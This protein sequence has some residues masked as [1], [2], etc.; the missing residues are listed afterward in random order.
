ME[1]DNTKKCDILIKAGKLLTKS[2][3]VIGPQE[4]AIT[5]NRIIAVGNDLPFKAD[6]SLSFPDDLLIPGL[7]DLHFHPGPSSWKY[8]V[9]P[10]VWTL[11]AGTTTV[12][13]QGDA[14]INN[15]DL[16]K[17]TIV[18]KSKTRVL[19]A[20]SISNYGDE[21]ETINYTN[22]DEIDVNRSIEIINK[23]SDLIWGVS[24]NAALGSCN[25]NNPEIIMDKV[26]QVAKET[27]K[28]ILYGIRREPFDWPIKNQLELLRPGD[29]VT[30][31]FYP[32]KGGVLNQNQIEPSVLDAREKGILFDVG[33]GMS[34]FDFRVAETCIKEGFHPDT[35][36]TDFYKRHVSNNL[37][38]SMPTLISKLIAVGM[39]HNE[40]LYKSTVVPAQ[41]LNQNIEYGTIESGKLAD[42]TIIKWNT[43]Q[44][45]LIDVSGNI[46]HS[47]Y[48]ESIFTIKEGVII[49][50][51]L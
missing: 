35:I 31:C 9:E 47:E 22:S 10:D 30:Y 18:A 51:D 17:K 8:A 29:V 5:G 38:H 43:D 48:Y 24:F 26:L 28:P 32:G 11:T 23:D 1:T 33:H 6:K 3:N 41:I 15:W 40:A 39:P 49:N 25:A 21:F 19:M 45:P 42:L 36:S 34:S 37:D 16:Y 27:N 14:G 50:Q 44:K 2:G 7:V 13:S 46:K 12:L 4:I 20:I